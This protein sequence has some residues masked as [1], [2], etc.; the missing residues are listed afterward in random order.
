MK[1]RRIAALALLGWYLMYPPQS[2]AYGFNFH[3]PLSEWNQL[4]AYDSAARCEADRNK[5]W[6]FPVGTNKIEAE[7]LSQG[8]CICS[9]DPRLVKSSQGDLN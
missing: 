4:A 1:L 8:R 6:A 5:K 7:R 9:D 3:A 2:G